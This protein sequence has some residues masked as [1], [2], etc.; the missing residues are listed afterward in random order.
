MTAAI[1]HSLPMRISILFEN[2]QP[3]SYPS[4]AREGSHLRCVL[5]LEWTGS[6]GELETVFVRS[7]DPCGAFVSGKFIPFLKTI[8]G[9]ALSTARQCSR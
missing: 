4:P 3:S 5:E 7:Y 2:T 1:E 9:W 6:G 8:E